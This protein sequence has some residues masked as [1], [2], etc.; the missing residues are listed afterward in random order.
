MAPILPRHGE[1]QDA[2]EQEGKTPR[3]DEANARG[4]A[5]KTPE[6]DVAPHE[7]EAQFPEEAGGDPE[8]AAKQDVVGE[9]DVSK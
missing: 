7:D 4:E 9:A 8:K 6:K 3:E 2:P 5:G 1:K